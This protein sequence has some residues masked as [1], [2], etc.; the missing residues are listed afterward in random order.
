MLNLAERRL[1]ADDECR[2]L[3]GL[4]LVRRLEC[5]VFAAPKAVAC[6]R[7]SAAARA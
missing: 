4:I 1:A 7:K 5:S 2:V 6:T 3:P